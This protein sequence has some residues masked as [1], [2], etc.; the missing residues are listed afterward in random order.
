MRTQKKQ[1]GFFGAL[2]FGLAILF[3]DPLGNQPAFSRIA[4]SILSAISGFVFKNALEF[5]RP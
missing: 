5:S 4:R 1:S 3:K 2:L